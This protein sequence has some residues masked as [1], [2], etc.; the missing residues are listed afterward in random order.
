MQ[1]AIDFEDDPAP[2]TGDLRAKTQEWITK[3]PDVF[4]LFEQFAEQKAAKGLMFGAKELAER[5]RW[6][7]SFDY[8]EHFKICNSFISYIARELVR[9][10]P[11]YAKF[12]RFRRTKYDKGM[13]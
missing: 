1:S 5:V 8:D 9:R 13:N 7:A 4:R 6:E 3:H 12:M 10:H 11:D 2:V